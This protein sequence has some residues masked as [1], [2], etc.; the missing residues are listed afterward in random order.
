MAQFIS[1]PEKLIGTVIL[2]L[3]GLTAAHDGQKLDEK[4]PCPSLSS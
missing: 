4:N 3:D 1:T 2:S